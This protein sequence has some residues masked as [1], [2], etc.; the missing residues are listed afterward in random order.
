MT[1]TS[2]NVFCLFQKNAKFAVDPSI[3]MDGLSPDALQA[4]L[5]EF[6]TCG[7]FFHRLSHFA[8]PQQLNSTYAKGLVF[9]VKFEISF[10]HYRIYSDE[11]RKVFSLTS[12]HQLGD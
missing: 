5:M 10:K 8:A 9:E 3:T 12:L 2:R 6:I 1:C 7:T 4:V 11:K